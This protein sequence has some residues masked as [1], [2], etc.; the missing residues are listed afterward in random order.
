MLSLAIYHSLDSSF[1]SWSQG[2]IYM[3]GGHWLQLPQGT[4]FWAAKI[5]RSE[6]CSLVNN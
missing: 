1:I 2:R 5:L 6:I 3:V 4:V